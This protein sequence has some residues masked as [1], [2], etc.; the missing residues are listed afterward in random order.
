MYE[1]N[2]N[3]RMSWY[4]SEKKRKVKRRKFKQDNNKQQNR[5]CKI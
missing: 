3:K 4:V 1:N 5:K 2:E